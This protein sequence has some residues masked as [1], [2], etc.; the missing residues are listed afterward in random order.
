MRVLL[1]G[2]S[3]FIGTNLVDEFARDSIE[4]LNLDFAAPKRPEHSARW[5]DVDIRNA[6]EV[7]REF[8]AFEPTH[9]V[10][11]AART[12]CVED[13]TVEE[14][15]TSNTI[16]TQCVANAIASTPSVERAVFVST[17]YVCGPGYMPKHDQDFRPHTVY[18]HSKVETERIV[19]ASQ[20]DCVWTIA[21]PVNIW[22][23]WHDRYRQEAWRVIGKGIY[24]HPGRQPVYRTYGFVG[25]VVWQLRGFLS[26][27]AADVTG[28]VFYVG[29]PTIDIRE[30]VNAFSMALRHRNVIVVPRTI[31]R[32]L[33]LA[34]DLIQGLGGRFPITS[35]R[36][37]SMTEDYAVDMSA[38]FELLGPPP[39]SLSEGVRR[40][41]EWLRT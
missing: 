18:G 6:A 2:A 4:Y 27:P 16:G 38:T 41:V 21:R 11:L 39:Y 23:P 33:G 19:R 12:D 25:N 9:V 1:T 32:S 30:W 26:A 29:D 36:F 31:V 3:G 24:L 8:K 17:Q 13:T 28:R 22:G 20:L 5:R 15:Y 35:S 40:T 7:V 14:G 34:G 10:H 37:R